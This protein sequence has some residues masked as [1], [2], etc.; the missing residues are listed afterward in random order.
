MATSIFDRIGN[1]R[2][3]QLMSEAV[4]SAVAQ[5]R[6]VGVPATGIVIDPNKSSKP[7]EDIG[8]KI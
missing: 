1:E 3:Q 6:A 2:A 5:A 8:L 7:T 4:Q